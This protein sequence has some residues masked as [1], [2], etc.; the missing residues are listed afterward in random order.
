MKFLLLINLLVS[1]CAAGVVVLEES[2]KDIETEK[3]GE[4]FN[5]K[6]NQILPRHQC[7]RALRN[8]EVKS[9][10]ILTLTMICKLFEIKITL[11]PVKMINDYIVLGIP[12]RSLQTSL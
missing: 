1:L 7:R 4:I 11:Y 6:V 9:R 12:V 10:I 8:I 2:N 5:I 3:L